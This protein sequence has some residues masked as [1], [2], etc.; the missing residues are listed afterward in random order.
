VRRERAL[1][2]IVRVAHLDAAAQI[3]IE[4]NTLKQF[5]IF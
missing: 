3:E 1:E 2:N 4:T 5:I